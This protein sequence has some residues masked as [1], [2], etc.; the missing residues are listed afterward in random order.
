MNYIYRIDREQT[1]TLAV[2][3]LCMIILLKEK[4]DGFYKAFFRATF[5]RA[6]ASGEKFFTVL[7]VHISNIF[8]EERS[9][10]ISQEVDLVAGD[11]N[12]T[13]RRC[14]SRDNISTIDEVFSDCALLTPPGPPPLW[15]PGSIPNN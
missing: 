8:A 14:R 2:H 15:G 9:L 7:S 13:A 5:R 11:F 6:A 3:E 10:M 4:K 12:G 1:E